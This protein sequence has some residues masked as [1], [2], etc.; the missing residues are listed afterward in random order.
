MNNNKKLIEKIKEDLD[1][2]QVL[3]WQL[4]G[5]SQAIEKPLEEMGYDPSVIKHGLELILKAIDRIKNN[6]NNLEKESDK[7]NE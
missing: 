5:A 2:I 3:V 6:L 7:K 4:M 1:T